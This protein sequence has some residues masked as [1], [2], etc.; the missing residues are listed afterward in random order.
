MKTPQPV[1][2]F[3]HKE[4][5][6]TAMPLGGIGAGSICFNGYGGLQDFA[7]R[8]RPTMTAL[9]D[10]HTHDDAAFAVLHVKGAKSVTRLLEGPFPIHKIYDQG[11][12][13]QGYWHGGHEG[14]PRFAKASFRSGYP[15]GEVTLTDPAVPIEARILA[16]NPFI[17]LDDVASGIPC[18]IVEYTLKNRRG[19]PAAF[20]FS[21]H[22]SHFAKSPGGSFA[23]SRNEVIPGKGIHFF[24]T[25][26]AESEAHGSAS[27]TVIGHRPRIKAMWLR[28]AWFDAMSALWKEVQNG[29]FTTNNGDEDVGIEGRNGGSILIAGELAPGEQVTIPIVIT[30][31]F[32]KNNLAEPKPQCGCDDAERKQP[33]WQ[34][35]YSSQWRTARETAAYV[36]K[37][38]GALRSRTIAFQ[39][40]LLSSTLPAE[41]LDA[42]SANLS[43][44]KSPTI[45]RQAN[46]NIWGWEGCYATAGCCAGTCTHVWNYA[47]SLPHLFPKLER[48]LREQE[49]ERSMDDTG[50][51]SFR[52]ALPDGPTDHGFH[53]AAD[54][55]LGGIMKLFRDWHI[56]GDTAWMK[57]LYPLAKRSL[58]FCIN[59]WD[60]ERKGALF[61]PHHNTYDIEFRGPDGMCTTVY[62]GA[63]SA[64]ADM[65]L[66]LGNADDAEAYRAL[67]E[68]GARY[69]ESELFNGEYFEQKVQIHGLRDKTL[70]EVLAETRPFPLSKGLFRLLKDEGPRY[71][72]GSGCLSDGVIGA[73]M[74]TLYRIETPID[75]SK[76]GKNLRSI[77]KYNFRR[78]LSTHSNCQRPGFALGSEPGLL[79]CTWP[80][81]GKP[82]LPFVYSDEVWTGIEYQVASHLILEGMVEEGLEIVA[83]VRSRYDGRVRNP[84]NE[85]ECGSYYARAMASYALLQAFSG[86]R[87]SAVEKTLW[88]G[89]KIG[90]KRFATFFCAAEGFGSI[91]LEKNAMTITLLQGF[92]DIKRV[93]LAQGS[94]A[95]E[96]EPNRV[97]R[98]G[99]PAVFPINQTKRKSS[100]PDSRSSKR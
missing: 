48:R 79:L 27:L 14:L 12:Q 96:F 85:Y 33:L 6:Q 24:N 32:P 55:Q 59:K 66:F 40:A 88:F 100:V 82:T 2:P 92:L 97:V 17:P 16:W 57:R 43:I 8:N 19:K 47:Q 63:L 20:E 83:G 70:E 54:G 87:Y 3:S 7:I 77:H 42:V 36:H 28:S 65:A 53:A 35:F 26:P 89:P 10:G 64:M 73:W 67:A 23:G 68:R 50:H 5:L 15:F 80:R 76:V 72:Y 41:V 49:W 30:W 99:K 94:R 9:P 91:S 13:S 25:E 84:W 34:T 37:N 45:L 38:F 86:F 60:P 44:L 95:V 69:I 90:R 4:I 78:D 21:Y 81:G 31:H 56:S 22:L 93:V 11:L 62:I 51:V 52:A 39:N 29:Q 46:G 74:A 75:S 98:A 1:L 58:E 71:Q 61:E 18:A